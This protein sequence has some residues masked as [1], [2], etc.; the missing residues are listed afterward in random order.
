MLYSGVDNQL[1]LYF[2]DVN[3]KP[4]SINQLFIFNME[5][6]KKANVELFLAHYWNND[7][8]AFRYD[9]LASCHLNIVATNSMPKKLLRIPRRKQ[10]TKEEA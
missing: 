5:L 4:M 8:K 9:D 1:D 2:P 7:E 6:K 10:I 3:D